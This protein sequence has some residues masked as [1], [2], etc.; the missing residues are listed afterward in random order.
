MKR[1]SL[2]KLAATVGIAFSA[3]QVSAH[4]IYIWPSYFTVNSEKATKVPVDITATHTTYRPDFAMPSSGVKVFGVDGKQIRR[5][6]N[7]YEGARRSTFDLAVEEEGTYG[8]KYFREGS[9]HTRFKVGRSDKFKRFRGNKS[10]AAAELPKKA[11]EVTTAKYATVAVSYLT[12]KAPT[13]A[14][15][16]PTNKGFEL[17][18]VTHPADYVTGEALEMK[19]TFNGKPVDGVDV[20]I[21]QEGP[22]YRENPEAVELKTDSDGMLAVTLNDGGRYI[23]KVNHKQESTDPEADYEITRLYYAFEVIF[24]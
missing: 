4:D 16:Q 14:V 19:F 17:V 5:R 10:Q 21:E 24:E 20:V 15:L 7:F 8:L 9:Y 1:A 18:P 11:K 23:L 12:N 22:Q 6:G 13:D 2:I 3:A